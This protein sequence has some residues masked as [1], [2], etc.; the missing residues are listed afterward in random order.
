V[1]TIPDPSPA[2]L[3]RWPLALVLDQVLGRAGL[4]LVAIHDRDPDLPTG[5]PGRAVGEDTAATADQADPEPAGRA[6][7]VLL[8]DDNPAMRRVLRGL[9]EDAGMQVVA[10][11]INGLEGIAQA[12][13]LLPDVVLMD[14]RMPELDGIQATTRIRHQLPRVQVVMFSSAEGAG[15]GDLARRAGAS[16]FVA[17]GAPPEQLCAAVLAA[18]HDR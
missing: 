5:R 18:W 2:D 8:V 16:A 6:P 3:E 9:L 1:A 17:K 15:S 4:R 7:R 14:W 11:A 13:A 10:E 12:Q